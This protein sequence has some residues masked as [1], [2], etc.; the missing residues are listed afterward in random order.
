MQDV[1]NMFRNNVPT[2]LAV[3]VIK[4]ENEFFQTGTKAALKIIQIISRHFLI[5]LVIL[6]GAAARQ[7]KPNSN[8]QLH[9]MKTQSTLNLWLAKAEPTV[10]IHKH[11]PV[12]KVLLVCFIFHRISG[13]CFPFKRGGGQ[14]LTVSIF[15]PTLAN[16]FIKYFRQS[17]KIPW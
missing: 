4:R 2:I 11:T 14:T 3:D 13:I 9:S 7:I 6:R 1:F 8:Q 10:L 16:Y 5:K 15:I 17:S 12:R